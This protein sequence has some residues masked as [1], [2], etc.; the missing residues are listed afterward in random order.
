MALS[1]DWEQSSLAMLS[2]EVSDDV[3]RRVQRRID[4]DTN[5][6]LRIIEWVGKAAAC[7]AAVVVCVGL[8]MF[9]NNRFFKQ[10][11]APMMI[12]AN[13]NDITE[14]SFPDGTHI[15]MNPHSSVN[16]ETVPAAGT[17]RHIRFDGIGHFNVAH[18]SKHPF[19]VS[20]DVLDVTVLGTEFY[21]AAESS[22]TNASLYLQNGAVEL[23]SKKTSHRINM[24][25]GDLA[26]VDYATGQITVSSDTTLISVFRISDK[27]R[28]IYHDVPLE[29]VVKSLNTCYAPFHISLESDDLARLKFTGSLSRNNLMEALSVL[30]YTANLKISV[31]NS[32]I[33]LY[34]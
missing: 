18:D 7:C 24:H 15:A 2:A 29:C 10:S 25:P 26:V 33:T 9:I 28:F 16:Y 34:R 20:T 21:L 23:L 32:Q 27:I 3:C 8:G 17:D 6:W 11:D 5:P 19:V 14:I 30:E 12:T 4:R 31:S 22:A 13:Q 1:D